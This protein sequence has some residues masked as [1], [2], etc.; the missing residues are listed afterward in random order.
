MHAK[1]KQPFSELILGST[2]DAR[3]ALMDAVGVPYRVVAPGVD[4]DL[5]QGMGV[6]D[7]VSTLAFRK[8]QAVHA[9]NPDALVI[10]C[11]Q[12]VSLDGEALGK[13]SDRDQARAQL[14]MLSGRSHEIVTGLCLLGP[15][16]REQY[17]EETRLTLYR[18]AE[19]ELERYLDLGEWEGC[20]GS[21]RVEGAGQALFSSIHGDRTNVQGLPMVLL[22]RLLR[23]V[24]WQ[25]FVR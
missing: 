9:R 1:P 14:K 6:A 3:R 11:D 15:G 25:F 2:S 8:A 18:L 5:P 10:G 16:V 20:A 12:L 23:H 22:V 24:G 19:D 13:P 17:V 21:Y 7:A 4:E